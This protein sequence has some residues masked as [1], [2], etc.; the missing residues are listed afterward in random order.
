MFVSVVSNNHQD[1]EPDIFG[2]YDGS[3]KI[4]RGWLTSETLVQFK[5]FGD[6]VQLWKHKYEG[7]RVQCM[8]FIWLQSWG[9]V[10]GS[11]VG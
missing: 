2:L 4:D 11:A 8:Q 1:I 7:R 9:G 3:K 5:L 10:H 6:S